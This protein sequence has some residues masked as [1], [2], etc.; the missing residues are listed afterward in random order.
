M[1][2]AKSVVPDLIAIS[3]KG[4]VYFFEVKTETGRLSKLQDRTINQLRENNQMPTS[5]DQ[6]PKS[7]QL[8]EK[9]LNAVDYI[10]NGD[11]PY[12]PVKRKTRLHWRH[13][14]GV[15]QRG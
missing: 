13:L 15:Y 14:S 3:P 12:V 5:S 4:V 11:Q 2:V 10:T 7:L 1:P 6:Q 8:S 9:Q